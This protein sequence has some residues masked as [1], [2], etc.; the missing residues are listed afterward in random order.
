MKLNATRRKWTTL[1]GLMTSFWFL[2]ELKFSNCLCGVPEASVRR[3]GTFD[4]KFG[5]DV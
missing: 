1:F 5:G 3:P 2:R 4:L